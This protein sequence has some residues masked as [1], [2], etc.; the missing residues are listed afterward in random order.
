MVIFMKLKKLVAIL[1]AFVLMGTTTAFAAEADV[2]PT[3]AQSTVDEELTNLTLDD[4]II[5]ADEEVRKLDTVTDGQSSIDHES[6]T[7]MSQQIQEQYSSLTR[8]DYQT[9]YSTLELTSTFSY[10]D[11]FSVFQAASMFNS[12]IDAYLSAHGNDSY[13]HFMWNFKGAL[14]LG[15]NYARIYTINYEWANV[16]LS[17]YQNYRSERYDYYWGEFYYA[18]LLGSIDSSAILNMA[19]ADA[20][21]YIIALRDSMKVTCKASQANFSAVFNSD[22]VMDFWNNYYGRNYASSYST[23]TAEEAYDKAVNNS[24]IILSPNNVTSRNITTVY[25]SN[26]WYTGT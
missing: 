10:A 23:L 19:T 2:Y 24:V 7:E 16:L 6:I 8:I 1:V 17:T 15:A 21:D 12:G 14:S 18:L 5:A 4:I 9:Q 13:R 25:N 22:N 20:D 3:N 11:G 26:W